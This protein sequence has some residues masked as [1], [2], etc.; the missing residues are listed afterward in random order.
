MINNLLDLATDFVSSLEHVSE[1][2]LADDVA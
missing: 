1:H 2:G